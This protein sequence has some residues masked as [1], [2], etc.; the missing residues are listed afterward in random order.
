MLSG[1]TGPIGAHVRP[2]V[3]TVQ[4]KEPVSAL[5]LLAQA[6]HV[7]TSQPQEWAVRTLKQTPATK[8]FV[9]VG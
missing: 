1:K 3:E 9:Q 2:L 8:E 5:Q 6:H 7:M 4:S